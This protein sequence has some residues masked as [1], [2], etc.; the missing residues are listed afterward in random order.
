MY[1]PQVIKFSQDLI[2]QKQDKR[3]KSPKL[4]PLALHVGGG[5]VP[6]QHGVAIDLVDP[7]TVQL[8]GLSPLLPCKRI[9]CLLLYLLQVWR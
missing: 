3:S 8:D 9:I 1:T 4:S 6:V 5:P 2:L 7:Q